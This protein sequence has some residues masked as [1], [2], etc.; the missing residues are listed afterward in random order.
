[1]KPKLNVRQAAEYLGLSK[2]TLDK[3]RMGRSS[4]APRRPPP[5]AKLG[6]RV[7]YDI[8]ELEAWR[9]DNIRTSTDDDDP[10][11]EE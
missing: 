5:Y 10:S 11:T 9:R 6:K 4:R 7:V 8:D 3:W 1:M 2:S